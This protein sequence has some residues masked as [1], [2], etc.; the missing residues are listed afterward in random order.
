M[1]PY[2]CVAGHCLM[3]ILL[4]ME[5]RDVLCLNFTETPGDSIDANTS[6]VIKQFIL[7]VKK[8]RTRKWNL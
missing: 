5:S 2:V 3:Q 4:Q 1:V 7:F 6:A 8:M